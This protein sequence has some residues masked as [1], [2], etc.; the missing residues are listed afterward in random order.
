MIFLLDKTEVTRLQPAKD[1][2]EAHDMTGAPC[3]EQTTF[4][5][6]APAAEKVPGT[7]G[8]AVSGRRNAASYREHV[9]V[10]SFWWLSP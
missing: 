1:T 6:D 8:A 9:V 4:R 7:V 10:D 3:G 2:R 5:L